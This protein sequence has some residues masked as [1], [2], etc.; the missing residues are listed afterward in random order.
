MSAVFELDEEGW[1]KRVADARLSGF[2]ANVATEPGFW[3]G[4]IYGPAMDFMGGFARAGRA[5]GIAFGGTAGRAMDATTE[6]G[7][8]LDAMEFD[9]EGRMISKPSPPVTEAQ[10]AIFGFT[11]DVAK[12]AVEFWR[13]NA[14]EVGTAGRV[15]GGLTGMLG[16]LAAG[17]G[18]PFV[19]VPTTQIDESTRLIDEGVD[20]TTANVAGIGQAA[21]MYAGFKLPFIGKSLTQKMATGAAGN[22]LL[23]AGIEGF[24]KELLEGRGYEELAQF[25]DPL[26]FESRAIDAILGVTFGGLAHLQTRASPSQRA[27]ATVA[28]N[29]RHYQQDTAPGI[30]ADAHAVVTHQRAMDA[31]M[32]ALD[33]GEPISL[34]PD[35]VEANYKP[36]P[37]REAPDNDTWRD[38]FGEGMPEAPRP[39]EPTQAEP[40]RA[41]D[42]DAAIGAR[43]REQVETD[44]DAAIAAY[45]ALKETNGGRIVNTDFVRELS[46]DF[47]RDRSRAAAVHSVASEL[48]QKI[49]NRRLAEAKP[50]GEVLFL[51]GGAGS[52]KSTGR[53][54][55]GLGDQLTYDGTLS[56]FDSAT[57]DI[58]AALAADQTVRLVYTFRDPVEAFKNGIIKRA[59]GEEAKYGSGRTV[60][61]DVFLR[62]HEGAREAFGKLLERYADDERVKFNVIDNSR[63]QGEAR[64]VE[65]ASLP[66]P[67]YN[68]LR[69]K[70]LETL[71]EERTS[72]AVSEDL[73][74]GFTGGPRESGRLRPEVRGRAEQ[75]R[76]P[77][78]SAEVSRA[79]DSPA[80]QAADER[81]LQSDVMI[82]TGEI[83]ADGNPVVRS[84]R[85]LMAEARAE[86]AKAEA[87]AKGIEAAVSCFLTRGSDAS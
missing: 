85:E 62:G 10:D 36:R 38:V 75:G 25:Y 65:F 71:D 67:E 2:D 11:D 8:T 61:V 6:V 79:D 56:N 52:G 80:I 19:L 86:I 81:L 28:A 49:F 12:N 48:S 64:P 31:A 27:A 45:D 87:D 24:E 1:N 59:V 15:I 37:V 17:G 57:K 14:A 29:A 53:D 78:P 42:D 5:G 44:V 7:R 23:G 30:P 82:A 84:G 74:R 9:D 76:S 21:G 83:D 68:G 66:K 72:G 73:Y 34:T 4:S 13:P 58:D 54:L 39:P 63:G 16:P 41:V 40:V 55:L 60:P 77:E 26:D 35:M 47:K 32:D 20:T 51:A 46:A 50:G 3:S 33:R 22:V 70:L 69:E 43:F 18:T